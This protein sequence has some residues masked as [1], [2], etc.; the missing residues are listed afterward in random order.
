[1]MVIIEKIEDSIGIDK[2]KQENKSID[3]PPIITG[4]RP[5]LSDKEPV[6]GEKNI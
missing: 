1:M 6:M 2:N 3:R 5:T 4:L